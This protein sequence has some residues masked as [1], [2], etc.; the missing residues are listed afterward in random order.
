MRN[1]NTIDLIVKDM[2]AATSFF[3][4]IV[5]LKLKFSEERFAELEAGPMTIMLSPDAMVPVKPA[6]GIILHF[7]VESVSKALDQ[8]IRKGATVILETTITDWG[9]K[10]AM[11]AGSED[12]IIDFY[13][14]L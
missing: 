10:S 1:F 2:P 9:T 5:G 12:I 3:Q 6:A 8:A 4:E 14:P 11:I 7:Q 13:R